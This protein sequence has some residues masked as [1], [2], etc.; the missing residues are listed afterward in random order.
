MLLVLYPIMIVFSVILVLREKFSA[1]ETV[2]LII[3]LVTITTSL[4][5]GAHLMYSMN[6]ITAF[7]GFYILVMTDAA[8]IISCDNPSK[9]K[10]LKQIVITAIIFA[11]LLVLAYFMVN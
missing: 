2:K 7:V 8:S 5:I 3:E 9:K 1:K 6:L 11:I 10:K 4:F